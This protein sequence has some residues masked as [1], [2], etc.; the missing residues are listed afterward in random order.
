M[1]GRLYR[2][3]DERI[4]AGVAGGLAWNLNIDPS[5]V[6]ILWVVLVP[7]TGGFIVLLYFV[8]AAIVPEVPVGE[9]RSAAW[10]REHGPAP[11]QGWTAY[12]DDP[13]SAFDP[14]PSASS[15]IGPVP[16]GAPSSAPPP[17]APLT[18]SAFRDAPPPTSGPGRGG[19]GAGGPSAAGWRPPGDDRRAPWPARPG[20]SRDRGIPL[21]FG[22]ILVLVGAFFLARSYLPGI[23]WEATWPI[24][25]VGIG[26]ALL[27]GSLRR[28][29]DP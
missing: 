20:D 13:T 8:M 15:D 22:L 11:D 1:N 27:V 6:R 24:L 14:A 16:S 2:S 25:L 19:P 5:I 9:D 10:E 12:S 17:N 7:L 18:P 29:K 23:D 4:I 21:V 3:R 26:V 28:S